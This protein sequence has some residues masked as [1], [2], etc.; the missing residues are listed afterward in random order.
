MIVI[1]ASSRFSFVHFV[2][3]ST[4]QVGIARNTP[5]EIASLLVSEKFSS[6]SPS[7]STYVPS[8]PS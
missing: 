4:R 6:C 3:V 1:F 7:P 8:R 2:G 5:C